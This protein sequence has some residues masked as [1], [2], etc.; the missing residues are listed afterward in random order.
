MAV[1]KQDRQ[2]ASANIHMTKKCPECFVYLPLQAKV[3]TSC[4]AAVGPV[5]KLGHAEKPVD[6]KGYLVA[7]AAILVFA[8]FIWWGFFTD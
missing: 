3:C 6:V 4:G 5:N 2:Q 8:A 7:A 1:S